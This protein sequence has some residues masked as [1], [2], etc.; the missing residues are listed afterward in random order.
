[1][2]GYL[3]FFTGLCGRMAFCG[4]LN[5]WHIVNTANSNLK[6]VTA[7]AFEPTYGPNDP[8]AIYEYA[9]TYF[10]DQTGKLMTDTLVAYSDSHALDEAWYECP[11]QILRIER[12]EFLYNQ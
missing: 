3:L 10:A 6:R 8:M 2:C 9:I 1:M 4:W 11:G 7:M 5:Q 12:G